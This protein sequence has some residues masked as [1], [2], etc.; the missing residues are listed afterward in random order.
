M[1]PKFIFI[2]FRGKFRK[3]NFFSAILAQSQSNET[4]R[5][6]RVPVK[7]LGLKWEWESLILTRR[8][9]KRR[10]LSLQAE[11]EDK[12]EGVEKAI[13]GYPLQELQWNNEPQAYFTLM[14]H[15]LLNCQRP[16]RMTCATSLVSLGL[17]KFNPTR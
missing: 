12:R 4:Y 7:Y 2:C 11:Q 14:D 5:S 9:E 6:E 13:W 15:I 17:A 3:L 8:W 16:P 1:P 10:G